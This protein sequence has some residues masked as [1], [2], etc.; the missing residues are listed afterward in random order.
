MFKCKREW[1]GCNGRRWL[2]RHIGVGEVLWYHRD[3]QTRVLLLRWTERFNC[4]DGLG[5]LKLL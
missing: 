1:M 2:V 5:E 4:C 3:E